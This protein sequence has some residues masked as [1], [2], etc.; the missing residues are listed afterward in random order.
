MAALSSGQLSEF[1]FIILFA[2]APYLNGRE[3]A[4]FTVAAIITIFF[5]SYL[6]SYSYRIYNFL[7]PVFLLFGPDNRLQKEDVKRGF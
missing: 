5:S 3:L 1:G 4:I 2:G 6:M 7:L